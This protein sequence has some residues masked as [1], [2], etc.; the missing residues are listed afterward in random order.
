LPQFH[1]AHYPNSVRLTLWAASTKMKA[2]PDLQLK[3]Q[4]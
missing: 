1:L 2:C 3:Q 4:T